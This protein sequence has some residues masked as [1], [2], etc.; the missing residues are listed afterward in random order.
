MQIQS[1]YMYMYTLLVVSQ[2]IRR[3]VCSRITVQFVDEYWQLF[4]VSIVRDSLR[5][6]IIGAI[7]PPEVQY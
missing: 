5:E 6:E 4:D 3:A 1:V 7:V 2:L